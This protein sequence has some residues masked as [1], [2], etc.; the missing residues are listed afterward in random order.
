MVYIGY[1]IM[2]LFGLLGVVQAQIY[3]LS[4]LE[5]H[6]VQNNALLIASKYNIAK[7][8]AKIVQEKLWSN[9]T[10]N[11]SEINIWKNPSS[12]TLPYLFGRYGEAQQIAV[13]LEQLVE[14]AG[15]RKKRIAIQSLERNNALLDYEELLRELK[16]QLRQTFN[17]LERIKQ[18]DT[19]LSDIIHLFEQLHEQ[20]KRQSEKQ[21]VS[22]TDY[23][24]IQ[25]ELI[26]LQ[27]E[28]VEL[29]SEMAENLHRLKV[30]TQLPDL[31]LD[32]LQ[33]ADMVIDLSTRISVPLIDTLLAQ[34]I[35]LKRQT[36][37]LD[38]LEKQ[39][40]LERAHRVP[41]LTFQLNYDRG[42]NIMRDF[43]GV[44]VS[45]DLPVFN[46]NKGNIKAAQYGLEQERSHRTYMQT[47]L[48]HEIIRL[49]T[50][51]RAYEISLAKW[52]VQQREQ[53]HALLEKY[54]KHLQEKQ[55]TLL[56]FIDFADA[57][58]QAEGAYWS[59]FQ[60]YKNTYEELQYIAG[61][62]F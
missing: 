9:P 58:R 7:E 43:I 57:F 60:D 30:L 35:G 8:E 31:T 1:V 56:E 39:V 27:K 6:F 51:L 37:T 16:K 2:I 62:D 41:D 19:Q 4:D 40:E 5:S 20:Y 48:G 13:E 18:E 61:R 25:S 3:T 10:L 38:L 21:H 45:F 24:R 12:E 52:N 26:G 28:K 36:N 33:F 42:G 14:T 59:L 34:H 49:Q 15:K 50:Q 55:I 47:E 44:G 17:H 23:Y 29:E 54:K 32:R 46:T 53:P 22:M 11:I